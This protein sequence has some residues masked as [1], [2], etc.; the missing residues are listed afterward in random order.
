M[1]VREEMNDTII[2]FKLLLHTKQTHDSTNEDWQCA[3]WSE[4][5]TGVNANRRTAHIGKSLNT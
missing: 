2:Q 4:M 3:Q 5:L 1:F